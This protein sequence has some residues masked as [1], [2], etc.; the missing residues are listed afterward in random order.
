VGDVV[1]LADDDQAAGARVDDVVD[2]LAQSAARSDYV[3]GSE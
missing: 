2:T 1:E 3:K